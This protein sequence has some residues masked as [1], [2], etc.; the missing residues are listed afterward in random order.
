MQ[1]SNGFLPHDPAFFPDQEAIRVMTSCVVTTQA[2]MN[3]IELRPCPLASISPSSG[4]MAA[5][6]KWNITAQ[7]RKMSSGRSLSSAPAPTGLAASSPSFPPR[8]RA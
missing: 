3:I 4:S 8:A 6:A 5:L 7:T 1:S 2:D